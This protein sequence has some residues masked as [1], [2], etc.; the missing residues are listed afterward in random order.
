[1]GSK[2]YGKLAFAIPYPDYLESEFFYY[3][4][5]VPTFTNT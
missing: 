1:M 2:T 4:K 5:N 3:V